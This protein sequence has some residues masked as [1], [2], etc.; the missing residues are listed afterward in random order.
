MRRIGIKLAL[1][2]VLAVQFAGNTYAGTFYR[3]ND[4]LRV[5]TMP[6]LDSKIIE[7]LQPGTKV[8]VVEMIEDGWAKISRKDRIYYV[9][10]DFLEPEGDAVI[11][12][13]KTPKAETPVVTED[14]EKPAESR[15]ADEKPVETRPAAE[16]PAVPDV[17]GRGASW[18][19]VV[20]R[21]VERD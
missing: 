7:T 4:A 21:A 3:T 10:A 9:K 17:S 15:P 12:P 20:Q 16:R 5:R 1:A 19:R 6:G 18:M 2:V 14:A 13:T 8:E 11:T